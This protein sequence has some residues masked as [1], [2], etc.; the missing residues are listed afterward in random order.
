MNAAVLYGPRRLRVEAAPDPTLGPD[1]ALVEVSVAGL[2]GTDYRIWNGDR[3]VAYPRV[4]GH[5][6]VGRVTMVGQ[7]VNR[8]QPGDRVV[9]EPNYSCGTCALCREGN[10]NLCLQRTA[11]GIDVDGGF[12]DLVRVPAHCCWPLPAGTGDDDAI[13]TEPLAVVVRAVQRGAPRPGETAA[14]VGAGTLGLLAI[15]VLRARGLRV[16][17]VSRT[18]TRFPLARELGAEGT[19][20][21]TDGPVD[22]VARQF[23]TREGLDL[24]VET[25]GTAEA[26]THALTL[27][28]PGGRV[29]LSGLPHE[30]T[31]VQFA[32]LVRREVTV[33]GSMI[34]RDEFPE[35]LRLLADGVVRGQPLVTHR[36]ALN[37]IDRAFAIHQES[38]SIKVTLVP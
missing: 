34:Y 15:Q 14:V 20:A 26:V 5:E 24:V 33:T 12:A 27:V 18:S 17:V 8:V 4:L 29:V 35:A 25:A 16:L 6:V 22:A 1:D 38:T 32:G 10:R 11:V 2:C 31:S 19:H 30:P 7:A 23:S 28:R 37:A 9:I 3:A 36:L 13:V 21:L